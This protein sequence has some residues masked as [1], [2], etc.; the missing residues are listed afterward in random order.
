MTEI[1]VETFEVSEQT[2]ETGAAFDNEALELIERL[3]LDGQASLI[4][5]RE[6]DGDTVTVRNPYRVMTA[7]ESRVYE[8]LLPVRTG[9]KAYKSSAIPLRVLQVAAHASEFFQTIEVWHPKER[10][11]DDPLL[12]GINKRRGQFG[13]EEE[14][15]ILAR[16]G[17][18]LLPFAELREQAVDSLR[19]KWEARGKS[20]IAEAEQFLAGIEHNIERHLAGEWVSVP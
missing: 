20:A 7:E 10:V 8:S 14:R 18:V 15:F 2:T 17:A 3:G 9:L 16:W 4:R 12:V 11:D 5:T 6:T 1:Q 19:R 13:Q